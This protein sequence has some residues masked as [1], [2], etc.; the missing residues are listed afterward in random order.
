[1]VILLGCRVIAHCELS[2]VWVIG[3]LLIARCG[4]S[5][6]VALRHCVGFFVP[7]SSCG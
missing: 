2:V 7:V 6:F 5:R 3:G 1:M 4:S